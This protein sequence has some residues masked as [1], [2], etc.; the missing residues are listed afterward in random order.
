MQANMTNYDG[1][2][3]A[4]DVNDINGTLVADNDDEL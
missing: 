4:T 3:T 1:I 2:K